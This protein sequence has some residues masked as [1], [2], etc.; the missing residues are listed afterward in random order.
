MSWT[1][2][3]TGVFDMVVARGMSG[4]PLLD[5]HCGVVGVIHGRACESS[6]FV[7]LGPVDEFI[8]EREGK[9]ERAL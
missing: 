2:A 4:G 1:I 3:P 8:E 5:L 7:G 6:F 9:R